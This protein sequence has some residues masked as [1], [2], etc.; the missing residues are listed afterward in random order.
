MEDSFHQHRETKQVSF[1]LA[2]KQRERTKSLNH[3][4]T[5]Q[6]LCTPKT[7]V[8]L[9]LV[10]LVLSLFVEECRGLVFYQNN[11]AGLTTVPTSQIPSNVQIVFLDDN[12]ISS[13]PDYVFTPYTALYYV[14]ITNNNLASISA[15]AFN[16]TILKTLILSHNILSDIPDFR[17]VATT[18][19]ILHLQDNK[20]SQIICDH[21]QG[22]TLKLLYLYNNLISN[23]TCLTRLKNTLT[24]LLLYNNNLTSFGA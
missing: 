22:S 17:T 23:V 10:V 24:S 2:Q 8:I 13:L 14:L 20:I 21:L 6:N 3:C 19:E 4:A 12:Y 16:N 9:W 1:T 11:S 5:N 7:K 18:L 15:T